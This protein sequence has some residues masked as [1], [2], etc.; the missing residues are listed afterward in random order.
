MQF[1]TPHPDVQGFSF[2]RETSVFTLN[3]RLLGVPHRCVRHLTDRRR[4]ACHAS[5]ITLRSRDGCIENNGHF[6]SV[7]EKFVGCLLRKGDMLKGEK[8]RSPLPYE[9]LPP[10]ASAPETPW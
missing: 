8:S 1:D 7:S 6:Y 4:T 3:E 5:M 10:L 9:S 2:H